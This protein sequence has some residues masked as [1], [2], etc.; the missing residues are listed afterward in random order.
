M[1]DEDLSRRAVIALLAVAGGATGTIQ[2]NSILDSRTGGAQAVLPEAEN[3]PDTPHASEETATPEPKPGV[4]LEDHG[5]VADGETDDTE[6]LMAALDE[7]AP[8]GTVRL[9]EGEILIGSGMADAILLVHRHRGVTIAGEGP[10]STRLKMA[11]GHKS[12]H[13][14]IV[15]TPSSRDDITGITIR[16]LMLDGQGLEQNYNIANGIEVQSANGNGYPVEIRNCVI[17]DWA[18][19]GLQ[20]REPGTSIYDSSILLNG[21]KQEAVTGRDGHGVATSIGNNPNGQTLIQRCLLQ[22]NTGAG[23]DNSGGNMMITGCVIDDCGYGVK[24]NETTNK[25]VIENTRI[26][27]LRT[28]P[29]VYNIPQDRTGGDLVLN[30]VCI[31]N[32]TDP[33]LL[34]PAGGTITGDQI[35]IKNTNTEASQPA[36]V[37]VKDEGRKFDIGE[38]AVY[39]TG[40]GSAMYLENCTGSIDRLVHDGLDDSLGQLSDVAVDTIA[41]DDSM[42]I[43]VPRAIDVGASL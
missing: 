38:L 17:Y 43:D 9:P 15:I 21:R 40:N 33:G 22:G 19:N 13:R 1:D 23:A 28:E 39:E 31:E 34:F 37:V 12:V 4:H 5:G 10:G 29:G 16:D 6:A 11:P 36:A 42:T 25:Q 14:G 18:T 30:N 7:A 20:L 32:A 41:N 2:L 3:G 8:D 27:N 26:S 24:Q 35:L